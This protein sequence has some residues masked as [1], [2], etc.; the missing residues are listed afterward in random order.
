[1]RYGVDNAIITGFNAHQVLDGPL[2]EDLN[3]P[4]FRP[5]VAPEVH[6]QVQ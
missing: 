1:M 5:F 4:L 6:L 3:M 2:I